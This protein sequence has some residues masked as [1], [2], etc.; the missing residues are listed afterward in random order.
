MGISDARTIDGQ[1]ESNKKSFPPTAE[2]QVI[3]DHAL[4]GDNISVKAFAGCGKTTTQVEVAKALLEQARRN[5]KRIRINYLAYNKAMD[6]E[7]K[8]KFPYGVTVSTMHSLALRSELIGRGKPI[9]HFYKDRLESAK[10][11]RDRISTDLGRQV[12]FIREF[13]PKEHTAISGILKGIQNFCYSDAEEPCEQHTDA[14][15]VAYLLMHGGA[16][17]VKSYQRAMS[18]VLKRVWEKMSDPDS[19]FPISH[20]IYLKVWERSGSKDF[21]VLLFD[22]GQD[23]N[24][25]MLSILKQAKANGAQIIIVG[26][27]HQAIYMWRGSV[28]AMEA[29][30]DFV[31][32]S[33]TESWRFGQ[34]IADHAQVFLDAKGETKKLIGKAR[35]VG[36]FRD[37]FTIS[38]STAKFPVDAI[39]CRSNSGVIMEA[40]KVFHE[41]KK[42][43]IVGGAKPIA[44]LLEALVTLK[45]GGKPW[46]PELQLFNNW[47]ELVEF[48]DGHDGGDYKPFVKFIENNERDIHV[49]VDFLKNG[50]ASDSSGADIVISTMHKAKGLEW[51][52][53]ILGD[54][55]Q[56]ISVANKHYYFTN[57][58][59]R[60]GI[61]TVYSVNDE[62][63]NLL[64]VAFTRGKKRFDANGF[65]ALFQDEYQK[66][67]E[68]PITPEIAAIIKEQTDA[69]IV[70]GKEDI[71]R[72]QKRIA[73]AMYRRL[74]QTNFR[75]SRP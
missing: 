62:A 43:F 71:E 44:D 16:D 14:E 40:L 52:S 15:Q 65:Y 61:N 26:D 74:P 50:T 12:D 30:P 33:L 39:L 29:F 32:C 64:Y 67:K 75:S 42:P 35:D 34:N 5:G 59:M 48:A 24:P 60:E 11:I 68:N 58:R 1:P 10:K 21:D 31:Q 70:V 55:T 19:D 41:H 51:D 46:H 3:I 47:G 25:V 4:A 7:A 36:V 57:P 56:Y 8:G 27:P 2:Q 23:A 53:V 28:N 18:T 66:I 38:E 6:E 73:E 9:S 72:D 49:I 22:E 13:F 54:D 37:G 63:T 17:T 69:G 20:D 45:S